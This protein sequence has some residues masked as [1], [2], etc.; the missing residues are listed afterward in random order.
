MRI[1]LIHSY[2]S[3]AVPSGENIVGDLQAHALR[4]AGEDVLV[5]SRR[6]DDV[7]A[8]RGAQARAALSVATGRGPDPTAQ[9]TAFK[10]DVVH[11]HNLFPN[12]GG[13]WLGH[14][15]VPVVATL[16]NFR[17][18]CSAGTLWRSGHDC[19][20][21]LT[22]GSFRAVRHGCYRGSPLATMPLAIATRDRGRTNPVLRHAAALIVMAPRSESTFV[23][24][25][26]D[27][28]DRLH[29]VP[30]FVPDPGGVTAPMPDAPWI[31][32]GRLTE[33]K[34]IDRLIDRWPATERLIV[35]GSGPLE[36]RL[37][38]AAASKAIDFVGQ[39]ARDAVPPL[40]AQ[41]RALVFPSLWRESAPAMTY[42]EALAAGRPTL[43]IGTNAVADDVAASGSGV[44]IADVSLLVDGMAAISARLLEA[45]GAARRRYDARFS[46]RAWL[47][48]MSG[49]YESV[50]S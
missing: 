36:D 15:T 44:V 48:Q 42:V 17:A 30:N 41:C 43:A 19:E 9:L 33:G 6:T 20:E 4:A 47:R 23:Q 11:V 14:C 16:H 10:P 39:V 25:R 5:V 46:E 34:G 1:A 26:P 7:M 35:V 8:R 49:I 45:S 37:K 40:L 22:G 28:E 21:C 3:S 31:F 24:M 18:F 50:V 13:A 2:Y 29:V 38:S 12:F 27:L 32:V